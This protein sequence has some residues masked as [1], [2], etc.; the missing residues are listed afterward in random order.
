M[1][2]SKW[3]FCKCRPGQKVPYPSG[4]QNMPLTLEQIPKGDNYGLL[5]G[6]H[7]GIMAIDF[8]GP[9]AFD[10]WE[11]S[12]LPNLPETV[13]WTS[14][15]DARA[16]FAFSV[17]EE[18]WPLIKTLKFNNRLPKPHQE[19]IEFRW[20]GAQS[21]LP[22]S[23]HP[24]TGKPYIWLNEGE[25]AE[26][27][28]EVIEFIYEATKPAEV[29]TNTTNVLDGSFTVDDKLQELV[30]VMDVV[31]KY[32][33]TLQYDDW[34]RVTFSCMTHVGI[35][36]GEATMATYY[37]ELKKGEYAVLGR[38]YSS[39]HRPPGI[40]SLIERIRTMEPNYRKRGTTNDRMKEIM[41][42]YRTKE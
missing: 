41:N 20:A 25:V 28:V 19:G 26:L 22:P 30:D 31:K 2:L 18:A 14:G 34:I 11:E 24:D 38:R 23:M 39:E 16:Q 5:T 13:S 6:P 32:F 37:P 7:S 15:K 21:V 8:D 27:P 12:G 33:P 9:W 3:K 36:A 1:D 42:K 17:P 29:D 40:G 35:N 10:W 4:W